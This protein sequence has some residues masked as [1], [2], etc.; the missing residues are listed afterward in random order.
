MGRFSVTVELSNYNDLMKAAAGIIR[1]D[2]V[3]RI[4]L[5]GVVDTGAARMVIPKSTS[6]ELGL[7][8]TGKV[9]VRYADRRSA[10]RPMVGGIHLEYSGREGIFDAIVETKRDTALIGAIVLET[11]DF[12]VD[13]INQ[14]LVPR[15]PKYPLAEIE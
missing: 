6:A 11:L 10:L 14:K 13:P 5:P 9:R 12:V 2:Q 1:K 8:E 15:D 7:E 4:S 3:R